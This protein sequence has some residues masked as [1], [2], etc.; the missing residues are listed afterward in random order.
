M[1]LANGVMESIP[2]PARKSRLVDPI[3]APSPP[4]TRL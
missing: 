2:M 3:S 4:K 1:V